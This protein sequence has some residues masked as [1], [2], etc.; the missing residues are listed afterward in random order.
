M[1]A[2]PK[3]CPANSY[4]PLRC[5]RTS[6]TICCEQ[7]HSYKASKSYSNIVKLQL[8]AITAQD[9]SALK[10]LAEFTRR[11][12]SARPMTRPPL[13]A[14]AMSRE[15]LYSTRRV[16]RLVARMFDD[17]LLANFLAIEREPPHSGQTSD[18]TSV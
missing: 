4:R 14:K 9:G 8:E 13:P 16:C 7:Y 18:A 10:H 6:G 3:P 17:A 12:K 1:A 5:I 15:A 2:T 11:V